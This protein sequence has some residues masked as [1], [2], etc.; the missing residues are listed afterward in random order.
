MDQSDI[1]KAA[2]P[3]CLFDKLD[4]AEA[5]FSTGGGTALMECLALS[6]DTEV[7]GVAQQLKVEIL[8]HIFL[9]SRI[10]YIGEH[11]LS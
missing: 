3:T 2:R 10:S 8:E 11:G 4:F 5:K 7:F 6:S 1:G 9:L